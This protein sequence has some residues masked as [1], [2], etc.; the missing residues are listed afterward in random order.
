ME[1]EIGEML[2]NSLRQTA[3]VRLLHKRF[4]QIEAAVNV[5]E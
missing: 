5:R 2:R 1:M 3:F 4:V